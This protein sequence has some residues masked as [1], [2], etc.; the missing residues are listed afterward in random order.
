MSKVYL[1]RHGLSEGNI[2]PIKYLEKKDEDI[3]LTES[4]E[5]Q[6]KEI[7]I[8][9]PFTKR[10]NF[11]IYSSPFL[12][13]I[14]TADIFINNSIYYKNFFNK[15]IIIQN[16]LLV[17][18]AWGE[19]REKVAKKIHSSE[20]FRFFNRPLNGES[21]F[22]LYQRVL[23]FKTILDKNLDYDK[24]VFTHGEWIK[25][26]DM[27]INGKT[28]KEFE[29]TSRDFKIKNCEVLVYRI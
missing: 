19:L 12:R 1:I 16:P 15:K 29:K 8:P 23:L 26:F 18:R 3:D 24:I 27:I 21:F 20:D 6:A 25:V 11:L 2:N 4:G 17:E 9:P 28:V 7:I 10:Y 5:R 22:D 14:K 13:A